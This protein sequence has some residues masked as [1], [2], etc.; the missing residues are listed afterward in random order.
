MKTERLTIHE[1]TLATLE[2]ALAGD[3][4]LAEHLFGEAP[5]RYVADRLQEGPA[6]AGWW[7]YLPVLTDEQ[8]LLGAGGYKGPPEAGVVEIGYEVHP[9]Y[10][11]KGYAKEFAAALVA[12]AWAVP[13]VQLVCAHTL[14]E[15]NPSTGVLRHL[16]FQRTTELTDPDVGAIW[17][18]EL[19]RP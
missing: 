2:A 8:V 7:T 1:C 6:H 12:H 17:R 10:R 16:G 11:G 5:L 18:W 14:A 9:V 15:L 3:G 13:D 4:H 19:Q